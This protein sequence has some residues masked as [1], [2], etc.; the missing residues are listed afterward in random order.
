MDKPPGFYD[1]DALMRM[2]VEAAGKDSGRFLHARLRQ[3]VIYWETVGPTL[4]PDWL[5]EVIV[6]GSPLFVKFNETSLLIRELNKEHYAP[7][8]DTVAELRSFW[9]SQ[10][11]LYDPK[12]GE[13][14]L[15]NGGTALE[16]I[17]AESFGLARQCDDFVKHSKNKSQ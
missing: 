4:T 5:G 6:V 1:G 3:D 9:I 15:R 13:R 12:W 8:T 7:A 17:R 16:M 2:V 14:D 11:Q 10:P